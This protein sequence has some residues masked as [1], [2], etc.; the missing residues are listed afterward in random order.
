LGFEGEPCEVGECEVDG[1]W[2][3]SVRVINLDE[4]GVEFKLVLP[5]L[6]LH[7]IIMD[8]NNGRP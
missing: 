5:L 1:P 8:S 3:K 2:L 6:K 4:F 7:F